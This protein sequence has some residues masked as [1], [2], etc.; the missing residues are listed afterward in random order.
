MRRA[1]VT[2]KTENKPKSFLS[3]LGG[4]SGSVA[5]EVGGDA[6]IVGFFTFTLTSWNALQQVPCETD[7]VILTVS[8][9]V[10]VSGAQRQGEVSR[11]VI[12][13]QDNQVGVGWS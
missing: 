13:G 1:R 7:K 9:V 3:F 4:G 8:I 11:G 2:I 5:I 10:T 12:I 6:I